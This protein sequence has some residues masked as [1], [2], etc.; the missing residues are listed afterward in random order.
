M[1]L[2][3]EL[4]DFVGDRFKEQNLQTQKAFQQVQKTGKLPEGYT[5]SLLGGMISPTNWKM[6]DPE[7][8]A[9]IN[10]VSDKF[11]DFFSKVLKAPRD[12]VSMITDLTKP[13][14]GVAQAGR[15]LGDFTNVGDK[16]ARMRI[17]PFA[18]SEAE[19][20]IP[21]VAHEM[22]HYLN[23]P[24]LNVAGPAA[25]SLAEKI[26][27]VLP[28][29]GRGS[30]NMRLGQIGQLES[31]QIPEEL[32][33][34]HDLIGPEATKGLMQKAAFDEGLAH[35]TEHTARPGAPQELQDMAKQFGVGVG[36]ATGGAPV[37]PP[38]SDITSFMQR[39][40][41]RQ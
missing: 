31:G 30:L 20:R 34:I 25:Q 4:I 35:L 10:T 11:P 17:A 2:M 7:T 23:D 15:T 32:K 13:Q 33:N 3:D 22:Q 39:I 27:K 28:E 16:M 12:L 36:Q 8:K 24:K 1:P 6:T 21:I 38:Q 14:G 41:G 5:S 37:P 9:L 26:W 29:K 40:L 19:S 18:S